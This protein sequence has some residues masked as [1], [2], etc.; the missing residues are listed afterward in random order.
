MYHIFT[1]SSVALRLLPCLGYCKQ[2]CNE[3]WDA[4]ILSYHVFPWVYTQE[5]NFRVIWQ[6]CF[7]FFKNPPYCCPQWLYQFTFL[8]TVQE[9]PLLSIHSP[10]FIVCGFFDYSNFDCCEVIFHCSFDLNFCNN[11]GGLASVIPG[12][13]KSRTRLRD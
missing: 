7:Q 1:H 11:Q 10:A 12:V 5:L 9:G 4:Y 8:P 2:C 6:I 3:H 13:A